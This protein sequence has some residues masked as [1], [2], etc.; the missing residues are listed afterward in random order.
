MTFYS[1]RTKTP[2]GYYNGIFNEKHNVQALRDGLAAAATEQDRPPPVCQ[3]VLFLIPDWDNGEDYDSPSYLDIKEK[4]LSDA[5]KEFGPNII[6]RDFL[7][8]EVTDDALDL[9]RNSKSMGSTADL[10]KT[11]MIIESQGRPHLQTDSNVV[12]ANEYFDD[13]YSD[14][15]IDNI[16]AYNTNR[17][18]DVY[19]AAHN[20]L[21]FTAPDSPLPG[22]LKNT[23]SRYCA[24]Y[25]DNPIHKESWNNGVYDYAFTEAMYSIGAAY[26]VTVDDKWN[27]GE[28]FTFYPA[29][30]T[31]QRYR[32]MQMVVPCQRE[33]W[34]AGMKVSEEVKALA[35]VPPTE[36]L[37][38]LS[39]D[40]FHFKSIIKVYTNVP[41]WHSQEEN[42]KY[43]SVE[44]FKD[45]DSARDIFVK[46]QS[47]AVNR[48]VLREFA[49]KVANLVKLGIL[50]PS[51]AETLVKL[52]PDTKVGNELCQDVFLCTVKELHEKPVQKIRSG[53]K[54]VLARYKALRATAEKE[55]LSKREKTHT[56]THDLQEKFNET[57]IK[58]MAKNE[59]PEKGPSKVQYKGRGS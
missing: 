39:A 43:N 25:K 19:I 29:K 26:K 36:L 5:K 24:K 12:W 32:L 35:K 23:L 1:K 28:T 20:K 16:D 38:H 53:H 55:L 59:K 13:L 11:Q 27:P 3:V 7:S 31:D 42:L 54:A 10:V 33:S 30:L 15:F 58:E 49:L 52:I 57:K 45:A 48:L 22:T 44:S 6:V 4:M 21:I 51:C 8:T 46:S 50:E 41:S 14:T 56:S 47:Y 40:Y 17:C 18:S 37:C 34:R 2:P 9:L